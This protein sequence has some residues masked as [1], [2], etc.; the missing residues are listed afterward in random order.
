[1]SSLPAGVSSP[2]CTNSGYL[3]AMFI[4]HSGGGVIPAP[5]SV[6]I[7]SLHYCRRAG[8]AAEEPRAVINEP[9]SEIAAQHVPDGITGEPRFRRFVHV[10]LQNLP[11][12]NGLPDVR[13]RRA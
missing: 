13:V 10:F 11:G 6:S 1:M 2:N 5:H 4:P 12:F 7:V 9:V 8:R 3:S